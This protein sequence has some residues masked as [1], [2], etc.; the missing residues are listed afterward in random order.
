M[1]LGFQYKNSPSFI[2]ERSG[3]VHLTKLTCSCLLRCEAGLR[4][5]TVE[6]AR[7]AVSGGAGS[8]ALSGC[9][10]EAGRDQGGGDPEDGGVGW[11]HGENDRGYPRGLLSGR[12]ASCLP[13]SVLPMQRLSTPPILPSPVWE[14][15]LDD[16]SVSFGENYEENGWYLRF[17]V[18]LCVIEGLNAVEFLWTDIVTVCKWGPSSSVCVPF[19]CPFILTLVSSILF[20]FSLPRNGSYWISWRPFSW[21]L[22]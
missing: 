19:N 1:P 20:F 4:H 10:E 12:L 16:P 8:Q 13:S 6:P 11:R 14:H 22:Q 18:E 7:G 9:G 21:V 5:Y 15:W 17:F 3:G 2:G